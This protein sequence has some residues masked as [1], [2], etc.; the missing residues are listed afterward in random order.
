[1][2]DIQENMDKKEEKIFRE[3]IFDLSRQRIDDLCEWL[4]DHDKRMKEKWIDEI[5]IK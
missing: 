4:E 1:M 2:Q 5:K 3:L